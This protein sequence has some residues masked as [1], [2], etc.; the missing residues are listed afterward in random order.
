MKFTTTL[1]LVLFHLAAHT[2]SVKK[3]YFVAT[4]NN[5]FSFIKSDKTTADYFVEEVFDSKTNHSNKTF[6]SLS[7]KKEFFCSFLN[8]T[9][10]DGLFVS[11]YP[12]GIV[13]DSGY[14]DHGFKKSNWYYFH[15]N[16][17]LAS[18]VKYS[19]EQMGFVQCFDEKGIADT[20]CVPEIMA[21]FPG[22]SKGLA[23]FLSYNIQIPAEVK[24]SGVTG[25]VVVRFYI[26]KDGTVRDPQVV[27]D[28]VG[29]GCAKE[30]I[31]VINLMPKWAPAK[32]FNR[33]IKVYYM[34]P[35]GFRPSN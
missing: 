8:D 12:S 3:N 23:T 4:K 30:A 34:L 22:E 7:G 6:Y 20:T 18:Q 13:S 24:S 1:F 25:E 15:E 11:F 27:S 28:Q 33:T 21:I 35:V 16:G 19:K 9:L 5:S 29:R 10:P 2:Q 32:Q 31:R 14:Y 17:Q 26:D